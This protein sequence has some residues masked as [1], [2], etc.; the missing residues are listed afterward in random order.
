MRLKARADLWD[1]CFR[2]SQFLRHLEGKPGQV[3]EKNVIQRDL[4]RARQFNRVRNRDQ[5]APFLELGPVGPV[6][7]KPVRDLRGTEHSRRN[8]YDYQPT[9]NFAKV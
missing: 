3:T 7:A 5:P 9:A 8:P 1:N 4:E 6:D 2:R